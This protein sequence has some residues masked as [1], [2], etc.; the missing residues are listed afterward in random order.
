MLIRAKNGNDQI[1]YSLASSSGWCLSII[2]IHSAL[3]TLWI[4]LLAWSILSLV[5]TK[6]IRMLMSKNLNYID[7]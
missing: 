1:N 5:G 4:Y 2:S 3:V 6:Y 7:L